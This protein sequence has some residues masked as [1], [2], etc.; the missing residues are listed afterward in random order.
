MVSHMNR[1]YLTIAAWFGAAAVALGAFGAH[2]LKQAL[3][4]VDDGHARLSWWS[5]AASYHLAHALALGLASACAGDGR[6][7]RVSRLGF[8]LGIALFSGSL[9]AMALTGP[10]ALGMVT[11][12]GGALLIV[13]WLALG[14]AVRKGAP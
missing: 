13:G 1:P 2:G 9:Y 14:L 5:T 10:S 12:I 6:A 7:A 11:P 8:A 3:A 4:D